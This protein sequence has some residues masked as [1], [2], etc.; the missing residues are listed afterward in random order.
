M[1]SNKADK[2]TGQAPM[3]TPM[4]VFKATYTLKGREGGALSFFPSN[5]TN[6]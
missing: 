2:E 1:G 3:N 5:E 4:L 6:C